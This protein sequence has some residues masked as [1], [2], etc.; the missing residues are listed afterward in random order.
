[1][2]IVLLI[3]IICAYVK[4]TRKLNKTIME[5][6]YELFR[7]NCEVYTMRNKINSLINP[8]IKIDNSNEFIFIG[9]K[10]TMIS[11]LNKK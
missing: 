10:E 8:P 6:K 5:L 11:I 7:T 9:L 2:I 3:C 4:R 1:M